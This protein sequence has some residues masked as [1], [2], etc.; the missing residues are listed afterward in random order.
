MEENEKLF[1][2]GCREYLAKLEQ[3]ENLLQSEIDA[4]IA[5]I[6]AFLASMKEL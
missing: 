5:S 6:E 4:R 1:V 3:E 2:E